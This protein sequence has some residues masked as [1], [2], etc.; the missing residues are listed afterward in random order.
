MVPADAECSREKVAITENGT[1]RYHGVVN[2]SLTRELESLVNRK[3]KTGLYQTASEVI[4]EGLRLL[5]E[6]DDRQA[7][8]RAEIR[9]G[10]AQVEGGNYL[11]YD[12]TKTKSLARDI[13]ARGRRQLARSKSGTG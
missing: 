1:I 6:R 2:I 13:K 8:L 11:E 9:A 12:A 7:Q 4:R 10:F 5:K 3:V